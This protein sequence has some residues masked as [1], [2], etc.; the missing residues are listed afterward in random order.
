[1][2][3]IRTRREIALL[4]APN[5]DT[6]RLVA[7]RSAP[8][9]PIALNFVEGCDTERVVPLIS[10][11]ESRPDADA[12]RSRTAGSQDES[13]CPAGRFTGTAWRAPTEQRRRQRR[14][15]ALRGDSTFPLATV[16][17]VVASMGWT[18]GSG[19]AGMVMKA[20]ILI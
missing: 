10:Y 19:S 5:E 3:Q 6:P 13:P 1:M 20:E 7:H 15:V 17:M 18:G 16:V 4:S 11:L 14:A 9:K 2:G 12:L 8:P